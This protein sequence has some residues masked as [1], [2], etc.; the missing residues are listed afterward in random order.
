MHNQ[1]LID[2]VEAYD[3]ITVLNYN[4]IAPIDLLVKTEKATPEQKQELSKY[5]FTKYFNDIEKIDIE[6]QAE[7]FHHVY[8]N[9]FKNIYSKIRK[10][11]NQHRITSLLYIMMLKRMK[12]YK[13]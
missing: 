2:Q 5:Y 10:L 7:L 12:C 1:D 11:R 3:A 6:V 13:N 8:N 4:D 9:T